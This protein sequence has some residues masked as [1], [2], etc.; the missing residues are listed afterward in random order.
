MDMTLIQRIL[1][2]AFDI[3]GYILI[4]R[5]LLNYESFNKKIYVLCIFSL[6]LIIAIIGGYVSEQHNFIIT[7]VLMWIVVYY[8]YRRNAIETTYLHILSIIIVVLVQFLTVALLEIFMEKIEYSFFYGLTS[9]II[10]LVMIIS[11][12]RY[13]PINLI[14]HFILKRNKTLKF[15]VL[16]LL[17]LLIAILFYWYADLEGILHN[18]ISMFILFIGIIFVNLVLLKNG[19]REEYTERQLQIYEKYLPVIDQLINELRK[20]QHEYDNH[21]QA[22]KM[23]TTINTDYESTIKTITRYSEQLAI[24]SDLG[25]LI[26][27]NNKVLAG[28]LYSKQKLAEKL[29]I[30]FE[31]VINDY[32]FSTRLLDYELV[33]V[34]GNLINNAFET[35]VEKNTVEIILS[36]NQDMDIIKVKNKHPYLGY[37]VINSMFRKGFSTKSN[38]SR[39]YGL[40]NLKEIIKKYKGEVS[41]SNIKYDNENYVVFRVSIKS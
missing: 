21:I 10:S 1:M 41:V 22:L 19:L 14:F 25:K 37:E 29:G 33:E 36:K 9:Q 28:F 7:T 23:L 27:L 20:R 6:S 17:C 5:K 24:Q 13:L 40:P 39:G 35:E 31:I 15:L 3:I 38:K 4:S 16:N 8:L 11:I 12:S 18:I 32:D 2:G 30:D 26:K 34:I